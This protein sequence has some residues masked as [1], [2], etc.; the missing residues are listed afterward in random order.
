MEITRKGWRE[1]ALIC[2]DLVVCG[3]RLDEA[4]GRL[5]VANAAQRKYENVWKPG[6]MVV[7]NAG[8]H[9]LD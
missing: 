3:P 5:R 1:R 4:P 2:R 6:S 9:W 8:R 7:H